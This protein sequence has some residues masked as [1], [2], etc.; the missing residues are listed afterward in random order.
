MLLLHWGVRANP[1]GKTSLFSSIYHQGLMKSLVWVDFSKCC[2]FSV[3]GQNRHQK[4]QGCYYFTRKTS[5]ISVR[6]TEAV[7][8]CSCLCLFSKETFSV[9]RSCNKPQRFCFESNFNRLTAV[10]RC[11]KAQLRYARSSQCKQRQWAAVV[12]LVMRWLQVKENTSIKQEGLLCNK[13]NCLS[14]A[15]AWEP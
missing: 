2:F 5:V 15:V 8:I 10:L 13:K 6:F 12:R 1:E 11:L 7:K 4:E 14:D 9:T 3:K